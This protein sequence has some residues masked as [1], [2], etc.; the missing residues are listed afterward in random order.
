MA[1]VNEP[2]TD[3]RRVIRL[4]ETVS[5]NTY[6]RQL[7]REQELEEGTLVIA[8][9]QTEG[10]GQMG[11]SWTSEKGKN[12]LFSLL[13]YPREVQANAQ[14]IISRIASLAVKKTID[15]FAD[16]IRVK[17]PNDIYWK[18]KK[19]AGMLIESDLRGRY[20]ENSVIGIGMNVN[21]EWFPAG[22]PNPVSLWQVT[23]VE[24]DREQLLELFTREFFLLYREFQRGGIS[25]IEDEYMLNLYRVNEYHWYEYKNGRFQAMIRDVL[26]SGYLVVRTLAEGEDRSYAFKEIAFVDEPG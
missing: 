22:L 4:E 16:D 26:P 18:D 23:G 13:V 19:I 17:W 10:R 12:L 3:D 9:F 21:Q 14:F 7:L 20:I 1:N 15:R 24:Q 2:S 8:D 6:M 25:T 5:T 11:N